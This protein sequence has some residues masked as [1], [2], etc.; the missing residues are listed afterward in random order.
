ML[1]LAH[2][3][4]H[5]GCPENTLAAFAE[6]VAYGADGIETDVRLSR[7]GLPVLFHDRLA[8]DGR[9]V[10]A[11]SAAELSAAAG[12]P[13][14]TLDQAL[15][16]FPGLFWNLEIKAPAAVPVT[17]EQIARFSRTSQRLLISSFWHPLVQPFT[18]FPGVEC[19]LL[20][21][22]RPE[23]FDAF[24]CLFP[25][26]GSIRTVVWN[27]ETVDPALLEQGRALGFRS[28]V[29]G[30]ETEEEHRHCAE[31]PLAGV[32]TD[33]LDRLQPLRPDG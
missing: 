16:R 30:V 29:Y 14:P 28:Y 23:S 27:Y 15:A 22:C 26:D 1:A 7:D 33:H 17:L 13:V 32:I 21:A 12:Y 2:R 19:G 25:R 5:T 11:L 6:A 9:E 8:P 18:R 31:L 24:A 20:L 10:A 4:R 3:G